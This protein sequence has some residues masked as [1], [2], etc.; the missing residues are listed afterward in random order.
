MASTTFGAR[1][2]RHML[3]GSSAMILRWTFETTILA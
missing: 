3:A 2:V 1:L